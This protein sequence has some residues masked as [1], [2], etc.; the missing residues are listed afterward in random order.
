MVDGPS[1]LNTL[2]VLERVEKGRKPEEELV[3]IHILLLVGYPV[4]DQVWIPVHA[5][6]L[7]NV[8]SGLNGQPTLHVVLLVGLAQ[9]QG[10]GVVLHQ[11]SHG[12]QGLL[13]RHNLANLRSADMKKLGALFWKGVN[14]E[15][16]VQLKSVIIRTL[17]TKCS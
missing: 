13:S 7:T 12:V 6:F 17:S 3:V 11:G 8:Q 9:G 4:L 14:L 2:S 5:N 15:L 16:G 1:G 10:Q